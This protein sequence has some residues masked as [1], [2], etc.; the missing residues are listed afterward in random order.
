MPYNSKEKQNNWRRNHPEISERWREKH[1]IKNLESHRNWDAKRR[2][3]FSSYIEYIKT[4]NR[5]CEICGTR[6]KKM[7]I[8]HVKPGSYRG[9]LCQQC[10]TRLGWFE[11]KKFEIFRY[12]EK[13]V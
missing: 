6:A 9:V 5:S 4:R 2:F 10:N 11:K 3:G 8:D 12:L 1:P 13:G 7:C